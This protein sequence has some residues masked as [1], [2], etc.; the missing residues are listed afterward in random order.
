MVS[1]FQSLLG[2]EALALPLGLRSKECA[3]QDEVKKEETGSS[4]GVQSPKHG[5]NHCLQSLLW[6]LSAPPPARQNLVPVLRATSQRTLIPE[7][8]ISTITHVPARTHL[9]LVLGTCQFH[10]IQLQSPVHHSRLLDATSP[11]YPHGVPMV[12]WGYLSP[13]PVP[14]SSLSHV[15]PNCQSTHALSS[16]PA[17]QPIYHGVLKIRSAAPFPTA[18]HTKYMTPDLPWGL[19]PPSPYALTAQHFS[20]IHQDSTVALSD[21]YGLE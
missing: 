14:W 18:H 10:T 15:M 3:C 4:P 8:N 12:C 20:E 19:R 17:H 6:G 21:S 1:L 11:P 5:E 16:L 13:I 9:P 7:F 2:P